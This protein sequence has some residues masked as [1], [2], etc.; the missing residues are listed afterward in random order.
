MVLDIRRGLEERGVHRG[1]LAA[2]QSYKVAVAMGRKTVGYP[3]AASNVDLVALANDPDEK[4][5]ALVMAR[6]MG[7][8]RAPHSGC[9][10]EVRNWS[11]SSFR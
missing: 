7:M 1:H 11:S 3:A 2:A 9:L 8:G 4:D 10:R 6:T 5:T